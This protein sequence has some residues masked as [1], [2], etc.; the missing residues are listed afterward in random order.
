M[1]VRPWTDRTAKEMRISMGKRIAVFSTAWNA[2]LIGGILR[3]MSRRARE[4]GNSLYIFNTYGGF[5]GEK[6]YNDCEY[7]IFELALKSDFDGAVIISNNIASRDRVVRLAA[8]LRQRNIPCIS[9]EQEAD[10]TCMVGTDNYAAMSEVVEHLIEVHKCRVFNYVGGPAANIEAMQRRQAFCDTLRRHGIEPEARRMGDYSFS[11]SD[12]EEAFNDF[13]KNGCLLAD[14][15]VCAN[16]MMAIGFIS[17]LEQC[18]YKVPEDMKVTGFDNTLKA[19]SNLPGLASV[20]RWDDELG[21]L[22]VDRMIGMMAGETYPKNE[23]STYEYVP[24]ES[25]GCVPFGAAERH[26]KKEIFDILYTNEEIRRK[27]NYM[28][29]RLMTAPS[30]EEF[31]VKLW[32]ELDN[33]KLDN[34][35]LLIDES[36]Y[37]EN[38]VEPSY[39]MPDKNGADDV[40]KPHSLEYPENMMLLLN[41][42]STDNR[43]VSFV[44]SRLIPDGFLDEKEES[45][46]IVFMPLHHNGRQFGYCVMENGIEY[47]ENGSLYYWLSV[48]NTALETIRQSICIR[49]LNKKLEH[50][51]MYDVMTGIYNRFAL[52]HVGAVL[53]ER[54]RREGRHTLFLFADMDGL[55]RINDTYGHEA[56]D[57]AIK[58]MALVLNDVKPDS[59]FFC[60]RYGGDEFLLMGSCDSEDEAAAIQTQIERRIEAYN[61]SGALPAELSASIGHI[62]SSPAELELGMEDYIRTA[63]KMMYRIKQERK[64]GRK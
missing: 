27:I 7:N 58:A 18:G 50:L 24:N 1:V 6:E 47:I 57:A 32:W 28:Q 59:S 42:K 60:L 45:H 53:F 64:K 14:A 12:G 54:N 13:A 29:T 52:Q 61:S 31:A 25:C 51:Y 48:L 10:G 44:T 5:H 62:I 20:K 15:V 34:F 4:T 9:V 21:R 35:C 17:K 16:D 63:D 49:E 26:R 3:G 2:E 39:E 38:D 30:L 46:T 33:F 37:K 40:L 41:K 56:G 55:K 36:Q 8:R 11:E 19:Q 22:C 43:P 23:Y